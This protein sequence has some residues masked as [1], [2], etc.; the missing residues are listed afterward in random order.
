MPAGSGCPSTVT[1]VLKEMVVFSLAPARQTRSQGSRPPKTVRPL[2]SGRWYWTAM[3]VR[4][5][6]WLTEASWLA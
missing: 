6:R 3:S 1:S 2:T 5:I 4:P